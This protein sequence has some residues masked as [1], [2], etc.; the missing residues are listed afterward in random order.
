MKESWE[1]DETCYCERV[2]KAF[3][4]VAVSVAVDSP[5]LKGHAKKFRLNPKKR[6]SERP[7]VKPSCNGRPQHIT[8]ASTKG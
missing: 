1:T 7:L 2:G 8:N 5:G 6:V 4:K 3:G